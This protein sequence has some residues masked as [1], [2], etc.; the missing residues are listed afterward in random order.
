V[1]DEKLFPFRVT[2][3]G[4][5]GERQFATRDE[6][7]EWINEQIS[8]YT[9]LSNFSVSTGEP[10]AG[11]LARIAGLGTARDAL[12]SAS[13]AA[14]RGDQQQ[15][16]AQ[17][18]QVRKRLTLFADRALPP[19][20]SVELLAIVPYAEADPMAALTALYCLIE[21]PQDSAQVPPLSI[22]DPAIARGIGLA[23]LVRYRI[24]Q[25]HASGSP[26]SAVDAAIASL[27]KFADET[28]GDLKQQLQAAGDLSAR[29]SDAWAT[30]DQEFEKISRKLND[31]VGGAITTAQSAVDSFKSAYQAE[32]ALK[33]PVTF[34]TEKSKTHR[35]A[36][37][38]FGGAA[39]VTGAASGALAISYLPTILSVEQG[40]PPPYYGIAIAVAVSTLVLW[41]L[42]VLVRSYLGQSHLKADA[43]ERVAM[44]KTYLALS[45]SGKAPADS[46]GPVLSALFRPASDGLV[47]DD[48]MPASIAELLTKQGK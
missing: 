11:L 48:S 12:A 15:Y 38:A 23:A 5:F 36:S 30:R 35:N 40:S 42:R 25:P 41:L 34:W 47:K 3:R 39:I 16:D 29:L 8:A 27:N 43:D 44:V 2:F 20:A 17:M 7:R 13:T 33:E 26:S 28:R 14:E 21:K 24:D 22:N 45:E 46:L 10:L 32:I 4:S 9:P 1:V 37:L 19:A 18:S 31:D 6:L